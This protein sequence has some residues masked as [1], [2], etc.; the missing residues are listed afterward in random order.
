M[1]RKKVDGMTKFKPSVIPF[2]IVAAIGAA[3]LLYTP[4]Y[5]TE[6]VESISQTEDSPGGGNWGDPDNP[7][8]SRTSSISRGTMPRVGTGT[9]R[10]YVVDSG[11]VTTSPIASRGWLE[12]VFWMLRT[13]IGW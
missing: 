1:L 10:G 12:V 7:D 3:S 9:A 8:P 11:S 13:H 2:L 4:V 5:A 6:G